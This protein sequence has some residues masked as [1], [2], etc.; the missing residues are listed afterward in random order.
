MIARQRGAATVT[1]VDLKESQLRTALEL[2]ASYTVLADKTRIKTQETAPN[3]F[4]V[5]I[6]AT[7]VPKVCEAGIPCSQIPAQ[8]L[9]LGL[10]RFTAGSR[11][12]HRGVLQRSKDHRLLCASKDDA[13]VH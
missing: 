5:I 9:H 10:T 11:S 2:G 12:I 3:G 8:L 7:G 6:E 4:D 13:A 1:I